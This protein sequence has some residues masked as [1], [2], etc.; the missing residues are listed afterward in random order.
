MTPQEQA[1]FRILR[2]LEQNPELTQRQLAEELGLSLGKVNYLLNALVEKGQVKVG[3]F[4]RNG[5]KL[6]KISYLLTPEGLHRRMAMTRSYLDRKTAEY[7]ALQSELA[8]LRA[9]LEGE[10]ASG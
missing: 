2:L 9:E 10:G 6:N 8:E 5:G 1:R 4:A 3:S 7:Q